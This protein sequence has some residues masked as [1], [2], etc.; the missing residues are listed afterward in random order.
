M[1]YDVYFGVSTPPPLVASGLI[2][3]S[4][5]P[6]DLLP[7]TTYYWSVSASD[8]LSQSQSAIWQFTTLNHAPDAPTPT[9][10]ADGSLELPTSLVLSWSGSDLDD[11]ALTY[12]LTFWAEGGEPLTVTGS[13]RNAIRPRAIEAGRHLLLAAFSQRWV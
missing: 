12:T 13:D 4:Y 1:T 8:G 2:E 7:H 3:T 10:P 9:Y 5:T 6:A 11:D